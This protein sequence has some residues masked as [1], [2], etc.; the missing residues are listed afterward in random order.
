[1]KLVNEFQVVVSVVICTLD[2]EQYRKSTLP[3]LGLVGLKLARLAKFQRTE[4][5]H[6]L[7]KPLSTLTTVES[8]SLERS[9]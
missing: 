3:N 4:I 5:H 6:D 7:R 1:M 9:P 2:E 8:P